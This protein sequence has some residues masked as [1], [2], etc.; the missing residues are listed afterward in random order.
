MVHRI[1]GT[2]TT[3]ANGTASVEL[4]DGQVFTIPT[5]D[6][7]PRPQVGDAYVL[8]F[9]SAAEAKLA[10]DDL[11]RSLLS[12]LIV[13]VPPANQTSQDEGN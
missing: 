13:D 1:Q 8:T 2:I 6:V 9:M 10:T 3:I 7:E 5:R 12:Q 11:A 4:E